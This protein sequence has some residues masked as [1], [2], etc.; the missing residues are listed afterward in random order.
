M[1]ILNDVQLGVNRSGGTTPASREALRNY[2]FSSFEGVL[3]D[4]KEKHVCILGDLFDQFEVD[5]RDWL[6]CFMVLQDFCSKGGK[7]TLVAGNHDHSPKALRVSSFEMLCKVLIEQF[8][9]GRVDTLGID[10][11]TR[12]SHPTDKADVFD[13]VALAHCSNQEVFNAKLA[14]IL[15]KTAT[16]DRILLHAN[17]DNNF[18]AQSDHSLNVTREQAKAF[19]SKGAT[20]CFAHEH[21]AREAL[22]GSVVVFGNQWPSSVADCLGNTSKAAHIMSGSVTK[23]GT[24]SMEDEEG[25]AEVDW[26]ELHS[27]E[28]CTGFIKVV[29]TA[30]ANEAG[31]CINAISKFRS[32][33]KAF[34]I[35]NG[36]HIE[37]VAANEALPEAFESS[38]AFDVMEFIYS[39]LDEA[40]TVAVKKL[41]ESCEGKS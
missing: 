17:F 35:T 1:L 11:W 13:I 30:S 27:P 8:G 6:Q 20:L 26:R 32:K 29:G 38:R 25:Y 22:G 9:H 21:Q 31:D 23:V 37:G 36:V 15:E 39:N 33:S 40:Q 3:N 34:V 16:G 14:E 41:M 7:L 18:A 28:L 10:Q 19:A 5:S 24:W 2:L 12:L 4:T